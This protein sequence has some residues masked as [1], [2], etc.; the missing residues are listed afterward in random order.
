[1]NDAEII[2]KCEA[3]AEQNCWQ[4]PDYKEVWKHTQLVRE[5]TKKLA[6]IEKADAL[7]VEVAAL[8]HDMGR[9]LNY[10]RHNLTSYRLAEVFLNLLN[11]SNRRKDLILKCI[12]L[13]RNQ[14]HAEVEN[15]IEVKILQSGEILATLFDEESFKSIVKFSTKD[16][17]EYWYARVKRKLTLRSAVALV[18]V[19]MGELRDALVGQS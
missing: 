6:E 1:M 17:L 9:H 7:V 5:Y 8:F 19:Q 13:H 16:E 4:G 11:L 3:Y 12:L 2:K 14:I 10:S 18:T 15:E